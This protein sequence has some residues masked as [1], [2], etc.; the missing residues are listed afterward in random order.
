MND[1]APRPVASKPVYLVPGGRRIRPAS[2]AWTSPPAAS[3]PSPR[4]RCRPGAGG[5]AGRGPGEWAGPR[6]EDGVPAQ[7]AEGAAGLTRCSTMMSRSVS[8]SP[9]TGSTMSL[10]I[11]FSTHSRVTTAPLR[12]GGRGGPPI[13]QRP[14]RGRATP[15]ARQLPRSPGDSRGPEHS[16]RRGVAQAVAGH[17]AHVALAA[18]DEPHSVH[19][20]IERRE[21]HGGQVRHAQGLP[22]HGAGHDA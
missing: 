20:A 16:A 22:R 18:R 21:A 11:S 5:E 13:N 19:G 2:R 12:G 8:F 15:Q 14:Q 4:S 9:F 1:S 7:G 17:G 10:R 3:R 6:E